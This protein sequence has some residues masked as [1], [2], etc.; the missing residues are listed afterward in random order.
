[1]PRV[2]PDQKTKFETDELFKKLV[3]E[4]DVSFTVLQLLSVSGLLISLFT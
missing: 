1:M 2:V 4:M 3:Q